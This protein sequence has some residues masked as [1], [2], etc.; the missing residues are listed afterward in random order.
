MEALNTLH[1]WKLVLSGMLAVPIIGLIWQL[2]KKHIEKLSIFI[3]EGL[4][5][6]LLIKING[7]IAAKLSLKRYCRLVSNDDFLKYMFVPGNEDTRLEINNSFI[8]AT[9][10][11]QNSQT[12]FTKDA[13]ILNTESTRILIIGD[14]G[15]GKSTLTKKIVLEQCE[16]AIK[17]P[18]LAKLPVLIEL[19]NVKPPEKQNDLWL[20][21]LAKANVSQKN[22]YK[23]DNCFDWFC[24][25]NGVVLIFDGL[26]EV[27]SKDL[28]LIIQG[29]KNTSDKLN[30]LGTNNKIILTMRSQFY[31]SIKNN[32]RE[33]GEIMRLMPF[34]PSNI[35]EFLTKWPYRINHQ[36]EINR[37]YKDLTDRASL[38]EMC[39]NPLV[40]SMYVSEDQA[41]FGKFTPETRTEFYER[42]TDELLIKRRTSQT[43]RQ[44]VPD[45]VKKQ[46][47]SVLS[48]ISYK[49][50]LDNK[51]PA[52]TINWTDAIL[53]VQ[54]VNKCN[55]AEAEEIL[56]DIIKETGLISEE[57]EKETL[58]FIHLT[59]CEFFAAKATIGNAGRLNNLIESH[60]EN[61]QLEGQKT[62]LTELFPFVCGL[63]KSRNDI[64]DLEKTL[65]LLINSDDNNLIGKCFIE[66]K[67]YDCDMW[68]NFYRKWEA[69]LLELKENDWTTS[70]LEEL[71]IF[72]I[73][74]RDATLCL[75]LLTKSRPIPDIESFYGR[76]LN[77]NKDSIA[78]LIDNYAKQDAVAALRIAELNN[79]DV[80]NDAP[81]VVYKNCD[82]VP[83]LEMILELAANN[84]SKIEEWA[85]ILTEAA[86]RS[87]I[88]AYTL[89]EK[90]P[91][92]SWGK[93]ISE[94]KNCKW[95][96]QT[97]IGN[98]LLRD[99]ISISSQSA[100]KDKFQLTSIATKVKPPARIFSLPVEISV[101]IALLFIMLVILTA[102]SP[103]DILIIDLDS[104]MHSATA[105]N[106][107]LEKLRFSVEA[108][109]HILTQAILI[110]T[111]TSLYTYLIFLIL[112][113]PIR[114]RRLFLPSEFESTSNKGLLNSMLFFLGSKGL[115][116]KF[117][118]GKELVEAEEHLSKKRN[119]L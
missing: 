79:L 20:F 109:T 78:K 19:K 84:N 85:C 71:H 92:P 3:T 76:F 108:I 49:H 112:I 69:D 54:E 88:V 47:M 74:S 80:A 98:G 25:S 56:L 107:N 50:L 65:L 77:K 103:T 114:I 87:K 113:K 101:I 8:S 91:I 28:T 61:Q 51:T 89:K 60:T 27:A 45:L 29:I 73:T 36:K 67:F 118:L 13:S 64:S 43:G 16:L 12:I 41:S 42:I 72:N 62:R 117:I 115:L 22:S 26:D 105:L 30:N 17:S 21:D 55:D 53:S 86:L 34:S 75:P 52:N 32:I 14:P 106:I 90:D 33:F 57:K 9:L 68:D 7:K 40:L 110:I 31:K 38:R 58:R 97:V 100:H 37:I 15:S 18:K 63:Q 83:F 4:L 39:S 46:R 1:E 66:S 44:H 81:E 111:F 104:L 35:Y 99:C 11:N 48:D 95:K 93:F 119:N 59:F 5:F 116:F 102:P 96:G 24:E 70:R 6:N 10:E 94:M 23:I 82:Q 2:I